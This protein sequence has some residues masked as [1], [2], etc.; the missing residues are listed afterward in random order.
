MLDEA[1]PGVIPLRQMIGQAASSVA[2]LQDE[3]ISRR[4]SNTI[5]DLL[6]LSLELQNLK[7]THQ[8]LDLYGRIMNYIQ[9]QFD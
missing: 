4:Y 5:I 2:L 1:R 3:G 9:R 6:V 8:E 7:T